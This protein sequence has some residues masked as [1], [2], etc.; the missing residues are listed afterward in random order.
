MRKQG[1]IRS[2]FEIMN[3]AMSCEQSE[4]H[5]VVT[6]PARAKL[7]PC[8]VFVLR[9]NRAHGPVG[10]QHFMLPSVLETRSDA[11]PCFS[12]NR[13]RKAVLL[14]FQILRRDVEHGHLHAA[15]N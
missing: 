13:A 4:F 15:G 1:E 12:L 9:R 6:T 2:R 14:S 5:K 11:K 10:I 7:G 8:L 3:L